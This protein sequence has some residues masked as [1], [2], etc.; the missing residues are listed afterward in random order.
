MTCVPFACDLRH[1]AECALSQLSGAIDCKLTEMVRFAPPKTVVSCGRWRWVGAD[2]GSAGG[3]LAVGDWKEA[4]MHLYEFCQWLQSTSWATGI[5]ESLNL[6]P[7]L[8]TLHIFGFVV[9]VTATSVLDLRV[10]GWGL[11]NRS[12]SSVSNL[13]LPWARAGLGANLLTGF[14]VFAAQAVDMYTNAAFRW[15]MVMVLLAGL[16]IVLIESAIK[17][18]VGD[19]GERGRAPA[20]ARFSAVLSILLWF[21]IV[22]MSRVIG[23][24][25]AHE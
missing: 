1:Q 21:G 6:Y 17:K 4:F 20:I 2:P 11:P 9:M 18:N 3:R 19:W 16:N 8:Y 13:A 15:K 14:L 10:L 25:G 7:G 12:V 22:A 24:T 5:R 23:F